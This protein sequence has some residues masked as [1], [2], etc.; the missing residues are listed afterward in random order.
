LFK[1][2]NKL[3]IDMK[4]GNLA[5]LSACIALNSGCMMAARAVAQ[6]RQPDPSRIFDSADTNGDG[7][8][9]REEFHA[10][11]ERMFVRLDRNGD[12]YIDKGD[13]SGR[14]AGRQKAQER[15]AELVTQL[16]RDG[17]GRVSKT[18]FVDGP[19]PLF[20][21]AD[22]DHNGELSK[23]EVAAIRAEPAR[24]GAAAGRPK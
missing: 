13:M 14:L 4:F 17:D 1:L 18:E 6:Q 23:E 15:L 19:T 8:I 22:T 20:D 21:R 7:V 11:R 2:Y 24:G 5:I 10:A 9:T 12:G 3:E 16:D